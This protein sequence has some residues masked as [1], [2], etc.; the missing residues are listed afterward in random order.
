MER[1]PKRP[2]ENI[3]QD[4]AKKQKRENGDADNNNNNSKADVVIGPPGTTFDWSKYRRPPLPPLNPK[5]DCIDFQKTQIDYHIGDPTVVSAKV[6]LG[7]VP[8]IRIYGVTRNGNS[9]QCNIHNFF[10]YFYVDVPEGFNSEHYLA[11]FAAL[12]K[13]LQADEG[14]KLDPSNKNKPVISVDEYIGNSIMGYCF[15]QKRSFI[16]ITLC[17][18]KIVPTIRTLLEK[19]FDVKDFGFFSAKSYESNIAYVLR[20]MFDV[21]LVGGGWMGLK[22]GTYNVIPPKTALSSSDCQL[23]LEAS[24]YDVVAYK[25]EGEWSVIAPLRTLSFDIECAARKGLFPEPKVDPVIQISFYVHEQG[26]KDDEFLAKGVLALRET[27]KF[28]DESSL[29]LW[30]KTEKELLLAW[31]RFLKEIDPDILIG[32]NI[33][34][35]DLYYLWSRAQHLKLEEFLYLGKLTKEKGWMKASNFSSKGYGKRES[36]DVHISGRIIFDILQVI[37]REYKLRS[38]SLNAVSARFLEDQKE[39]V[40]HSMITT[41]FEGTP[42]DRMRLAVYNLKDSYLP[43]RLMQKLMIMYNYM[44]M[45]RVTGVPFDYLTS[46]GQQIKVLSQL[47]RKAKTEDLLIPFYTIPEKGS[48]SDVT[49]KGATVME[50]HRGFH[51]EPVATLDF[52]SLYPTIMIGHNLCY[53]TL[54]KKAMTESM[55]SNEWEQTPTGDYF[56]RSGTFK[57]LLPRILEELLAARQKVKD[58]LKNEKDPFKKAVLSGRELALKVSTN[59]VYGFTGAVVGRLPCMAISASVTAYGRDMIWLAKTITEDHF[60]M[61]NGYS[62]NPVVI[63]GDTV[64]LSL[65]LF[66]LWVFFSSSILTQSRIRSWS[67]SGRYRWKSP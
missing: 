26:K 53:S 17:S 20:F 50:P 24:W 13:F 60:S 4:D 16:K 63:Y 9:V 31:K 55:P 29:L 28:D 25:P 54:L 23:E 11:L 49:Y 64:S 27:P 30:F 52:K 45:A 42:L 51:D 66:F 19:G 41:L 1:P 2:F 32:Y 7:K 8:I 10:P 5:T 67:N 37:Q 14:T 39:D 3:V 35:F 48:E 62:Q 43:L 57:G 34:N 15:R 46:K 21:G 12:T 61:K 38:Y 44:E 22:S 47:Y 56:V 6:G 58:E 65:S 59:S 18:P 33:A 36:W 40:D